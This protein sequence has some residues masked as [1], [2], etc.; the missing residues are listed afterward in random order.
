MLVLQR[1]RGQE[2]VI[3]GSIRVRVLSVHRS[4]VRLGIIAPDEIVILRE[5][6][7]AVAGHEE[8]AAPESEP[9]P[10]APG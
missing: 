10:A 7:L 4:H 2:V 8:E 5:E 3:G 9:A 6:C 1:K